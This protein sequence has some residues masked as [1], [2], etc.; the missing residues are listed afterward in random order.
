MPS[1]GI[2][3]ANVPD[4]VNALGR[5]IMIGSGGGIHAH[6]QGPTAGVRAFRQAIEAVTQGMPL[7]EYAK[8]HEALGIALGTWQ[9]KTEFKI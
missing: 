3:P 6:P 4:I 8:E 7:E 9:K 2:T 5:E 1:G